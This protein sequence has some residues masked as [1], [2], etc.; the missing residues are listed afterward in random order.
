MRPDVPY[1]EH[2]SHKIPSFCGAL[3]SL[4]VLLGDVFNDERSQVR[5]ANKLPVSPVCY[6]Q[7]RNPATLMLHATLIFLPGIGQYPTYS[8]L[9]FLLFRHNIE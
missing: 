6:M 7:H 5:T 2:G 1:P 4:P 3:L 8:R 9:K